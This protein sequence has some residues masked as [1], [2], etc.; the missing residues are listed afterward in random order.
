MKHRFLG[1]KFVVKHTAIFVAL[2]LFLSPFAVT[3]ADEVLHSAVAAPELNSARAA[4]FNLDYGVFLLDKGKDETIYP[5]SYAKI[6]T[7]LL[8]FEYLREVGAPADVTITAEDDISAGGLR[9]AVGEVIPYKDLLYAL[10]I[11]S[12]NDAAQVLAR[13]VGGSV[14]DFV[15]AMDRRAAELGAVNTHFCNPT[16]LHNGAA[17]TTLSD[18]AKICAQA[19]KINDYMQAAT[20]IRYVV[21]ATNLSQERTVTNANYIINPRTDLGYHIKDALGINFGY[22]AETGYCLSTVCESDD[23]AVNLILLSGAGKNEAGQNMAFL[24]AKSLYN[25]A[26]DGFLLTEILKQGSVVREVPVRLSAGQDHVLL[27]AGSAVTALLPIQIDPKT[28]VETRVF[29]NAETLDAPIVEGTSYGSAE[30]YFEGHFA[31]STELI[32]Q[33]S[34][35]RS[36]SLYVLSAV[37]DFLSQPL[38]RFILLLC[39]AAIALLLA[40]CLIFLFAQRRRKDGLTRAQRKALKAKQR[41]LLDTEKERVRAYNRRWRSAQ[42]A[43]RDARRAAR[44]KQRE[45]E[46]RK[47]QLAAQKAAQRAQARAVPQQ[48]PPSQ[49]ARPIIPPPAPGSTRG[50]NPP[51]AVGSTRGDV[52]ERPKPRN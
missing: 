49:N 4:V 32:A 22:T 2:A 19:Y 52:R 5:A 28:D 45:M 21:A 16:G 1:S 36:T 15:A 3:A 46:A 44:A 50:G 25:Y 17:Y 7:A 9:L 40:V 30:L 24:D 33:R 51:P 47:A 29:L 27:V 35:S 34:V 14:T 26:D 48:N 23:G 41:V 18:Q 13:V 6:M 38:V 8:C 39:A 10:A 37:E 31:G 12:S 42:K 20:Q 43:R 11:G